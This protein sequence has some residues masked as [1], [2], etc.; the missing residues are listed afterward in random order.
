MLSQALVPPL[1]FKDN[2]IVILIAKAESL[3]TILLNKLGQWPFVEIT[4]CAVALN[5]VSKQ[6]E[7]GR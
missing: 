6:K 7:G 2:E 3:V 4:W 1:H 5:K